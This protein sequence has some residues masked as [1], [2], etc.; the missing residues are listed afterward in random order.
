MAALQIPPHSRRLSN[1]A[2]LSL[3]VISVAGFAAGVSRETPSSGPSPFPSPPATGQRLTDAIPDA[4]P[5]PDMQVAATEPRHL[6]RAVEPAA[7]TTV[8]TAVSAPDGGTETPAAD[9]AATV[10][11]APPPPPPEPPSDPDD[12]PHLGD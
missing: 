6:R 2:V 12:P 1:I 4:T 3:S 10:P 11:D 7:E 8:D 9:V 5:A